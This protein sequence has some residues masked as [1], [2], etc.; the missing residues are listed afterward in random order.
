VSINILLSLALTT[1]GKLLLPDGDFQLF[2][3]AITLISIVSMLDFGVTPTYI[4]EV[5]LFRAKNSDTGADS[6][7]F[8]KFVSL[9][10]LCAVL[11][12]FLSFPLLWTSFPHN[13]SSQVVDGFFWFSVGLFISVFGNYVLGYLVIEERIILER[14]IRLVSTACWMFL[15]ISMIYLSFH[16]S[17]LFPCW[18]LAVVASRVVAWILIRRQLPLFIPSIEALLSAGASFV[19]S[20]SWFA[21]SLGSIIGVQASL[22]FLLQRIP[23]T[24]A[25][26]LDMLLKPAIA[27]SALVSSVMSVSQPAI[28]RLF[29]GDDI[30][31]FNYEVGR[32]RFLLSVVLAFLLLGFLA[33]SAVFYYYVFPG[34]QSVW[35][36]TLAFCIFIIIEATTI[37]RASIVMA[38]GRIVFGLSSIV[39]GL[40]S[41][42]ATIL[43]F[44]VVGVVALPI[45]ALLALSA[46]NFLKGWAEFKILPL[47]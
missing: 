14:S 8:R 7:V 39:Y 27:A 6:A 11:A 34:N 19:S 25:Y 16:W 36:L 4:R 46:T 10:F 21:M 41:F 44:P 26:L 43:L 9:F 29:G 2:L 38:V 24:D 32:V 3:I 1:A 45:A 20:I 40:A 12:V 23:S 13:I 18:V 33:Y 42:T 28:S 31:G 47:R 5:I 22:I 37:F 35:K 30:A 17:Y 15:S